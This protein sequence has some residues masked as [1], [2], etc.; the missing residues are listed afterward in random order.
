MASPAAV[1]KFRTFDDARAHC[2]AWMRIYRE[3]SP[4]D[5]GWDTVATLFCEPVPELPC[6]VMP[7]V[8]GDQDR[9]YTAGL[10][11]AAG[12]K[13][14]GRYWQGRVPDTGAEPTLSGLVLDTLDSIL[15]VLVIVS[16]ISLRDPDQNS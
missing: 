9:G 7:L 10:S 12:V 13:Y 5:W 14:E 3:R 11:F 6:Y 4:Y 16:R 15:G 8:S 2:I 1:A